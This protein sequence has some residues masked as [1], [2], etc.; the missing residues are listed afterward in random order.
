[1]SG[2]RT[3]KELSV[4]LIEDWTARLPSETTCARVSPTFWY[5]RVPGQKRSWIPVEIDVDE[6][7]TKVTSHVIIEPEENHADVFRLLLRHNHEASGVYYSIDGKEGVICLVARI[8]HD[9]LTEE[10]LDELV[11][12]MVHA[13]E[14]IFRSILTLGFS[15]RLRKR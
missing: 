11:G 8:P 9:T 15:A 13:T 3:V 2:V 7:S 6:K 5:I 14:V 4:S 1:M 10:R 12:L